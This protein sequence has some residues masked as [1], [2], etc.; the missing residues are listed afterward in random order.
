VVSARGGEEP[1]QRHS[2]PASGSHGG[3]TGARGDEYH[4]QRRAG[5]VRVHGSPAGAA[6]AGPRARRVWLRV[7]ASILLQ[8]EFFRRPKSRHRVD[9]T[10]PWVS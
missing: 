1:E 5:L 6:T 10:T 3:L 4:E 2:G 9:I 8:R 7:G